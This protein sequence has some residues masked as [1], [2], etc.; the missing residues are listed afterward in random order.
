MNLAGAFRFSSSLV[1]IM[2]AGDG[3]IVDVNPAFERR[4]GYSRNEVVG[5]PNNKFE[6]WP[7]TETRARLWTRVRTEGCVR[8]DRVVF[9]SRDGSRLSGTVQCEMFVLDGVTL[10]FVVIQDVREAGVESDVNDDPGNY[11][12]LFL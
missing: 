9:Q 10:M 8:D 11:R 4:V 1:F 2:D 5:K 3:S 6:F 7:D 12:A